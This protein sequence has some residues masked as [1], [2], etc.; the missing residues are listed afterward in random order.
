MSARLNLIGTK[1]GSRVVI[2][3]KIIQQKQVF[4]AKC[5]LCGRK[6]WTNHA[7]LKACDTCHRC[8]Q[9]KRRVVVPIGK[10]FGKRIVLKSKM[11]RRISGKPLQYFLAKC[12]LCGHK[13]W[14]TFVQL[15]RTRV[16]AQCK[17][18]KFRTPISIGDQKGHSK[19]V[20]IRISKK[21]RAQVCL[22]RCWCG[23]ERWVACGMISKYSIDYCRRCDNAIKMNRVH[24][25]DLTKEE[26][27]EILIVNANIKRLGG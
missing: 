18:L 23:N 3:A 2:G 25:P 22:M 27:H 10:R 5:L 21:I 26:L 17:G 20:A 7:S 8:A 4:L 11:I 13:C 1:I 15:Q 14:A 19:V 9:L 6:N 16:C 24:H 12:T